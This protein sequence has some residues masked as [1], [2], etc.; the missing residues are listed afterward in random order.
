VKNLRLDLSYLGSDYCG[1]QK[2]PGRVTV[3]GILE[4]ELEKITGQKVKI[5]GAG[6]T[7][8]GVHAFGQ[9]CNF[10]TDSRIDPPTFQRALNSLLPA[11]LRVLQCSE[12]PLAF[13]A[14]K[15]AL[16]KRYLYV[17]ETA[18]IRSPFLAPFAYHFPYLLQIDPMR[19][20]LRSLLGE[21]DFRTFAK[22]SNYKGGTIRLIHRA[23]VVSQLPSLYFLLEGSGFLQ[24]MVRTIVGTVLEV[25][26][27]KRPV[28]GFVK[29]L[30]AKDRTVA[31]PTI[32]P[33]GLFLLGV[34]YPNQAPNDPSPPYA[35]ELE[36]ILLSGISPKTGTKWIERNR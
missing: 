34:L 20:A 1:F 7:D 15:D 30:Q 11:S 29:A 16:A 32:P 8:R 6:R 12:V 31:G 25:G 9:V 33:H 13:H 18:A 5:V 24:H 28:E 4:R 27:G 17:V 22:A 35:F 2:L 14:R 36:K 10:L 26:R 19:D 23:D 21:Q 3:Q